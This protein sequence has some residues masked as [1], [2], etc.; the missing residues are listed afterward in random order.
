MKSALGLQPPESP[1]ID[2]QSN[3][4]SKIPSLGCLHTSIRHFALCIIP[5]EA[6]D[7]P[8]KS[9]RQKFQNGKFWELI[10][11]CTRPKESE[12]VSWNVEKIESIDSMLEV[13]IVSHSDKY[14]SEQCE[15]RLVEMIREVYLAKNYLQSINLC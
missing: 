5:L 2:W 8:T 10:G 14:V 15:C 4:K 3:Q 11:P 12:C 6:W 13:G 7:D 1:F 9:L